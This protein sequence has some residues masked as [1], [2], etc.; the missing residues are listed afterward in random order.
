MKKELMIMNVLN[1]ISIKMCYHDY[2]DRSTKMKF[3]IEIIIVVCSLF[4]CHSVKVPPRVCLERGACYEGGWMENDSFASFQGIRYAKSP[5]GNLRFK[6]P[7]PHSEKDVWIDV[8][9]E[10]NITCS[11]LRNNVMEGQE[12]CLFLNIYVPRFQLKENK[13]KLPVMFWIHG[14]GFQNGGFVYQRYGPKYFM[15]KNVIMVV[16]NYRLGP[17]GFFFMEN[18]DVPGNTGLRDQ[19]LAL[20]WVHENIEAFGGDPE[21]VTIF[22]ESAGAASVAYH[23]TSPISQG[24]FQRAIL[25]SGTAIAP[26]WGYVSPEHALEYASKSFEAMECDSEEDNLKC[27]QNKDIF[28]ILQLSYLVEG[29]LMWVPVNDNKTSN[30]FVPGNPKDLLKNGE[31][32]KNIEVILGTNAD[33]GLLF[34]F[35]LILDPTGWENFRNNFDILG[36]KLLFNI[37]NPRDITPTDV[38]NA[39]TI[40]EYYLGSIDNLNENHLDRIIDMFTDAGFLYGTIKTMFYLIKHSVKTYL[41]FLTYQGRF[42]YTQLYGIDPMGVCHADDLIYLWSPVFGIGELALNAEESAIRDTMT[43]AWTNFALS[44]NPTPQD[45]TWLPVTEKRL[46]NISSSVPDNEYLYQDYDWYARVLFWESVFA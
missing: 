18:D 10:S 32:D 12:D 3:H 43:T 13:T 19:S 24:L 44:G 45:Q 23:I 38:Q 46:W 4:S 39:L 25:Q 31:F 15:D 37:A 1:D 40:A 42:S 35:N 6:S 21:S 26:A 5:T 34:I 22:G 11:Q 2:H 41:Y 9:R 14:G 20:S 33:E 7:V 29:N 36:P 8:S 28:D 17:L 27:L 30:P 16:I